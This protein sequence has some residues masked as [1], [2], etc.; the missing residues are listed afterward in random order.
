M[1]LKKII[2]TIAMA[3]AVTAGAETVQLT[4]PTAP[5]GLANMVAIAIQPVITKGMG[6]DDTVVFDFRPGASGQIAVEHVL[7]S[8]APAFYVGP[9]NIN[10]PVQKDLIPVV[11]F[12]ANSA[13]I[14]TRPGTE[15]R[16]LKELLQSGKKS[17]SL[18]YPVGSA[19]ENYVRGL[20][21][22]SKTVEVLD[23]PFKSGG[24]ALAAVVGGH[25]DAAIIAGP[26]VAPMIK[27]GKL[28]AL[29]NL[30]DTRS[31]LIPDVK[32]V[33]EQ[34]IEFDR[35]ITGYTIFMLWASPSTSRATI[36][37]VRK[38][39]T[40][41]SASPEGQNFF[42]QYDFPTSHPYFLRPEDELKKIFK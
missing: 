39:F 1:K 24:E 17:V 3:A 28:M 23:V 38:E 5:G 42:R 7:R 31:S 13:F 2:S 9:A 16:T 27:E 32:G 30:S 15:F 22:Y 8:Q 18:A 33:H 29:G 14:V 21:K 12:G 4:L 26:I 41:W 25:V 11:A 40:T 20:V 6:K 35:D 19:Q 37:R 36:E 10:V 34:G